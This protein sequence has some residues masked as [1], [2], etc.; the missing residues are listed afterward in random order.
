[1]SMAIGFTLSLINKKT[2][3]KL[4]VLRKKVAHTT[5]K[6]LNTN[7]EQRKIPTFAKVVENKVSDLTLGKIKEKDLQ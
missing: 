2:K 4:S 1:M 6:M 7:L 5:D 3:S